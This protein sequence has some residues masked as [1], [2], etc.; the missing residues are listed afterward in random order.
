MYEK[1]GK[2][3]MMTAKYEKPI[4]QKLGY[5]GGVMGTVCSTGPNNKEP[6]GGG[7]NAQTTCIGGSN[8]GQS[9]ICIQGPADVS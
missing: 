1:K 9:T 5:D 7:S 8:V 4:L 3:K 6:C 2:L